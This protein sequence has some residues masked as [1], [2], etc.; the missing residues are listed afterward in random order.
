MK[1]FTGI[2]FILQN[3][4]YFKTSIFCVMTGYFPDDI[5]DKNNFLFH[6]V[7]YII[8][9]NRI[10][11]F[12]LCFFCVCETLCMR[13]LS[14]SPYALLCNPE[15]SWEGTVQSRITRT[16]QYSIHLCGN[17][18]LVLTNAMKWSGLKVY[19]FFLHVL[20]PFPLA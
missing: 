15:L 1:N 14:P 17:I 9:S 18:W 8:F 19:I 4:L 12:N 6:W 5:R 7:G 10:K 20:F 2:N 3:L 13:V 16:S 11:T